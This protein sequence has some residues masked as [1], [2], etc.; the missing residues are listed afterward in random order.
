M[1]I[2]E[3]MYT[4]E[5]PFKK[6]SGFGYLENLASKIFLH[7]ALNSILYRLKAFLCIHIPI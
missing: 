4:A 2:S 6:F 5:D 7:A 1:Y 3:T